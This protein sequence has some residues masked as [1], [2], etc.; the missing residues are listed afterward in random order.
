MKYVTGLIAAGLLGIAATAS[1]GEVSA[2]VTAVSDYD[3]RG[4]SLSAKDPALQASLDFAADNGFY[5]GVW[6]SNL[7]YGSDVDGDIEVDLYAGF[8]G[9]TGSGMGWD[10]GIVWYTYPD[11]DS[12]ATKSKI[13]DYPE[14]YFSIAYKWFKFKQWYTDDYGGSDLDELYSEVNGTF[15]LPNEF[16]LNLHAGYNYGDAFEDFEYFDFSAGVSR[17]VGHFTLGLK[18]TGTDLDESDVGL[19]PGEDFPDVFNPEPRLVFSVATT[20]PWSDE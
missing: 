9:E 18:V 15:E 17:D 1:A 19:G 3:F 10:A 20:F 4:V 7:D 13:Q 11:S 14:I 8:A 5:A 16:S 6:A 12:S 2:T